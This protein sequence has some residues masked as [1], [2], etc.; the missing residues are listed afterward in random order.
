MNDAISGEAGHPSEHE[1]AAVRA[2]DDPAELA[3]AGGMVRTALERQA[4]TTGHP[5]RDLL[6]EGWDIDSEVY[7]LDCLL[8]C[9][10]GVTIEQDGQCPEGHVSPLRTMGLI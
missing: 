9:P 3:K 1:R 5:I 7:G 10:C 4:A 8:V 2:I 6:P